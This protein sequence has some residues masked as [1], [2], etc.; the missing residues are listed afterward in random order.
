MAQKEAALERG[1][2]QSAKAHTNFLRSE[3]AD[4]IRKKQWMLLP[5]ALVMTQEELRISPL[6]VLPQCDR[7]P[8]SIIDYTFFRINEETLVMAP[9]EAMQFGKALW[10]ILAGIVHAN[11]RLGP[12][13]LSKVG[14]ADVFYR[15]WVKAAD[16]PKLGVLIPAEPGQERLIGFPVV[17]PIG[18]KESSQVFTSATE[19][20][21]DLVNDQIQQGIKQPPHRLDQ[22]SESCSMATTS[23]LG[24][25]QPMP[26]P[27]GTWV[28]GHAHKPVDKWGVY[29][30]DFIGLAQETPRGASVSNAHYYTVWIS[31]LGDWTMLMDHTNKNRRQ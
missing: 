19:T 30:D 16:I 24:N 31:F 4:M 11:P 29:V 25:Q 1:P 3:F 7:R 14:I 12:V 28:H 6:G 10:C 22:Q 23:P 26:K 13:Y 17:L 27:K 18:W 21:T 9:P 5:A 8:Q 15:I 20:V 2:H